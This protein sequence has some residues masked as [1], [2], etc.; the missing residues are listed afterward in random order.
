MFSVFSEGYLAKEL[1]TDWW[2]LQAPRQRS[3][4]KRKRAWSAIRGNDPL[5]FDGLFREIILQNLP[6][7]LFLCEDFITKVILRVYLSL[8]LLEST[9]ESS[10]RNSPKQSI[11][12]FSGFG[13]RTEFKLPNK[14]FK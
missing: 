3:D 10:F 11:S 12:T 5:C 6:L 7:P 1:R 9:S 4:I 2:D 14:I 13:D 8:E